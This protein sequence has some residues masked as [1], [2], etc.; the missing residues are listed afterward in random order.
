M[1]GVATGRRAAAL[2]SSG[3][4][5][6]PSGG[7]GRNSNRDHGPQSAAPPLTAHDCDMV[8]RFVRAMQGG[9]HLPHLVHSL[10]PAI[11][12]APHERVSW[13][14]RGE[15]W[16]MRSIATHAG[17]RRGGD[18]EGEGGVC[19]RFLANSS[20]RQNPPAHTPHPPLLCS[21]ICSVAPPR[22]PLLV[23]RTHGLRDDTSQ[24]HICCN[25]FVLLSCI[26][27]PRAGQVRAGAV[28]AGWG[29][30]ARRQRRAHPRAW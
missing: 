17:E 10:C 30:Q 29:A 27:R 8:A 12:G 6:S 22:L 16:S 2:E 7:G 20:W 13:K 18:R 25:S 4:A 15:G 11:K 23:E 14:A 9:L 3:P 21:A 19:R 24:S 26:K 5:A 1:G 28:A